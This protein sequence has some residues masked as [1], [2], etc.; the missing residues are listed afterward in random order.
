MRIYVSMGCLMSALLLGACMPLKSSQPA[1]VIYALH[2][3]PEPRQQIKKNIL[4]VIAVREP[5]VPPGF[6]VNKIALYLY[7]TRR[8]DYYMNAAWPE[9]LGKI[10]QGV[11]EQSAQRLPNTI[12]ADQDSGIPASYEIWIKVND[13]EPV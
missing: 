10:L 13:F 3:L 9:R 1:P 7:N 5:E 6:N 12:A 11:I 4:H 8:L 2:G